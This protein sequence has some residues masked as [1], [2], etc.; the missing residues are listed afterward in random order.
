MARSGRHGQGLLG[1][2]AVMAQAAVV[3]E[4]VLMLL[5][6]DVVG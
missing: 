2:G 6:G 3:G 5:S 1:S 4:G